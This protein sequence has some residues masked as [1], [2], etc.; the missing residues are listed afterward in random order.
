M[1]ATGNGLRYLSHNK[2]TQETLAIEDVGR[3]QD[4]YIAI[5]GDQQYH[6]SDTSLAIYKVS[7]GNYSQLKGESVLRFERFIY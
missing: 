2:R 6:I 3:N 7:D 5:N 1:C 4:T